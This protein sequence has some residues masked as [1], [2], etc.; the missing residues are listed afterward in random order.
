MTN[1]RFCAYCRCKLLIDDDKY[2]G[3]ATLGLVF[4]STIHRLS[5]CQNAEG[6]G[7]PFPGIRHMIENLDAAERTVLLQPENAIAV[8]SKALERLWRRVLVS[9]PAQPHVVTKT[10]LGR[11]VAARCGNIGA[12]EW[13][14]RYPVGI[15]V[16]YWPVLPVASASESQIT[17]TRSEAWDLAGDPV[18]QIEGVIGGGVRLSHLDV[19]HV[20][21]HHP[22][23]ASRCS[24]VV[25][26]SETGLLED[27]FC[28]DVSEGGLR[29][30][31]PTKLDVNDEVKL[32][33]DFEGLDEVA[34]RALVRWTLITEG[35][36]RMSGLQ[37][38]PGQPTA[39]AGFRR[40]VHEA[41]RATA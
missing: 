17:K 3:D 31:G 10:P 13:N 8:D 34:V 19:L 1:T 41:S 23:F 27:G 33:L 40:I 32:Y 6:F 7:R 11:E 30:Q 21:R 39:D 12:D 4:C 5:Y 36:V 2:T 15:Q 35:D 18:V 38:M 20:P 14:Q 9:T 37:L 26:R 28:L 29:V 24:V 16:R 22:R 25:E